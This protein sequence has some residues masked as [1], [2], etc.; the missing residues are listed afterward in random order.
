MTIN[1]TTITAIHGL[2]RPVTSLE[3]PRGVRRRV[4]DAALAFIAAGILLLVAF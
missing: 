3:V 4:E 1:R 2:P